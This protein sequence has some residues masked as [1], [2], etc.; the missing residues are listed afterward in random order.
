M[1]DWLEWSDEAFEQARASQRPVLLL[2]R[3]SWCRFCREL[4]QAVL[5]DE[6]VERV[7]RERFVCIRVD[8]DR[9][10]DIDARYSKGGWPTLAWLDDRGELLT[11]D[12]YLDAGPLLAR[13]ELVADFYA[14]QRDTIRARIAESEAEQAAEPP[15]A[16]KGAPKLSLDIVEHVAH[17]IVETADPTYGGWGRE[18]KFPQTEALDFALIRWS[19]TGEGRML[20]LVLRTLRCMQEGE[21][22][23]RVEGG[24]YRYATRP[25]WSLPNHEKMLDSNAQRLYVYLEG[26]QAFGDE[27]FRR[28]AEGVLS[29]MQTTLWD[30][31][32]HAFRGSQDADPA[33]AHLPMLGQ[34][35]AHGAPACDP[36]IFCNWNAQ[37]ASALFKAASVLGEES[38][39]RTAESVLA[40]LLE[41]LYDE[42]RGM[43]H[44]WDGTYHLPGLLSDQA[45][46][47]R[48]LL[49]AYSYTGDSSRLVPARRL[50]DLAIESL[51]SPS[52][53][54]YDTLYDPAA[55]GGLRRRN[56]SLLENSIM[57]EAL[58]RLAHLSGVSDYAD[59]AR[60][61]LESFAGDYKRY[62]H[63]TAG[64]AR[65]VDLFFHE[66]V[67]VTIVGRRGARDTVA[68]AQAARR[69]YVASRIVQLLDP[70]RDRELLERFHLPPRPAS[71]PAHAYVQRGR[72]SY[73]DTSDP[74]RLPA[75]M[76]RVERGP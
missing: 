54:F 66:P 69:P 37:A 42:S 17:T 44:Y 65:A 7:L 27:S 36:T 9:R 74:L 70:E 16:T 8:K 48:A 41:E 15:A 11:A 72:E 68:L 40:F 12:T 30:R 45:C 58:L 71:E 53:G 6:R 33:Y 2:V 56:R 73:A 13:A 24:F 4:E 61:T 22:H 76:T 46:T 34:R 59:T 67:R 23:D 55:Q 62:G 18:H 38:H 60:E 31:E 47:L 32:L 75:L 63:F 20:Q 51:Q 35:R 43:Y 49:D 21:I 3:A 64:Y 50:A 5:G 52:G 10:P 1:L 39:A 28:T 19:Q 29:W 14:L 57:A 25:D 26:W